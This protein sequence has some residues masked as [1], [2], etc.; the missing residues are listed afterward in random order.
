MQIKMKN[1]IKAVPQLFI[2]EPFLVFGVILA[3]CRELLNSR[4]NYVVVVFV[5]K[6][7]NVIVYK[8]ARA[9]TNY[10]NL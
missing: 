1:V 7:R 6:Q 5:R 9:A 3:H 10:L 8:L 4:T 2:L